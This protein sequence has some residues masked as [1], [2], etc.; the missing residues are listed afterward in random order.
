MYKLAKKRL[1][2]LINARNQELLCGGKKGL[3]KESLRVDAHGVIAQTSHP[4]SLG[5]TVT[6]PYITTDYSEALLELITP[7][8]SDLRDTLQFLHELHQFVTGR[9]GDEILWASSMPCAVEDDKSI[10]IAEYGASNVGFMKHVYRRGLEYR[11]GRRMQAI[12]GVHFNYS[13]PEEFWSVFKDEEN[14]A[15]T[16]QDF[17]ADRYFGLIRNFQRYAWLVPYLFGASPA[18]CKS[19]LCGRTTHFANFDESTYYL[20]YATSL[21]MSDIGYKNKNQAV[22]DVSYSS[23]DEY[24]ASLTHAIETPYPEYEAVGVKRDGKYVQLSTNILQIENEFYSFVRPKQITLSGEKPSVALRKGGVQYVEI[25]ALDVIAHDPIGVHEE[26]LRFLEAF[27]LFCLLQESPEI[28]EREQ[29]GIDYNE[30][31]VALRGREPG[32]SLQG[33]DGWRTLA[34]W[35]GELFDEIAPFCEILDSH[36]EDDGTRYDQALTV[37]RA[38]LADP[39]LLPSTQILAAMREQQLT[40]AEYAM[41]LSKQHARYFSSEQLDDQ[42][43]AYHNNVAAESLEEKKRLE[44]SDT[45]TFEKYLQRYFAQTL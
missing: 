31:T 38:K 2:R 5:A 4:T 7:P 44:M 42:R 14:D 23:L 28:D 24:V 16:L 17:V 40:F 35:A 8:Y 36:S 41:A 11:Y 21:R 6:H 3:E 25:R 15:G 45:M 33:K 37:Q 27:L 32:L 19:F 12:S 9:L 29:R 30:R 39:A 26:Q 43:V 13:V 22:L 20:P 10:P 1:A 34:N 18:V